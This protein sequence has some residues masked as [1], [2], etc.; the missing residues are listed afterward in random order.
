LPWRWQD[1]GG[2]APPGQRCSLI[3]AGTRGQASGVQDHT[4]LDG[5]H[6]W[7]PGKCRGRCPGLGHG[8][9]PH[10]QGTAGPRMRQGLAGS[11]PQLRPLRLGEAALGKPGKGKGGEKEP[12]CH[13]I[14]GLVPRLSCCWSQ[15]IRC[16]PEEKAGC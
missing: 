3:L 4:C 7:P 11:L 8:E 6:F 12:L 10:P 15:T 14:P 16:R 1:W 2:P 13:T 9:W 5:S